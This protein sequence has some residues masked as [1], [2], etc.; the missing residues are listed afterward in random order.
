MLLAR[1]FLLLLFATLSI[2][3]TSDV[4]SGIDPDGRHGRTVIANGGPHMDPNGGGGGMDPNGTA[5]ADY[6]ACIDPN[7]GCRD[8]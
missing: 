6:T 1:F 8:R 2:T 5:R 7:G 3:A 4:G